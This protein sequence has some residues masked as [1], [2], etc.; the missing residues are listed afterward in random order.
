[1]KI[2]AQK[3]HLPCESCQRFYKISTVAERWDMSQK[4]VRRMI[5]A[6]KL[7]VKRINGCIR[8][9]HSEI[10]RAVDDI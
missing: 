3:Y 6:G 9:S 7:K 8:V 10:R 5:A 2:G 4:T 1:M